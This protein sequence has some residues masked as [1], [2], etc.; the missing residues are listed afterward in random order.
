MHWK[1]VFMILAKNRFGFNF[2]E[3]LNRTLNPLNETQKK[4][5][6]MH[7]LMIIP[8]LNLCKTKSESDVSNSKTTARRLKQWHTGELD[9]FFNERK[10]LQTLLVKSKKKKV[11]TEAQ[12]FNKLTNIGNLLST[13]A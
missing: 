8:H 10:A 11:E 12:Q 6:A 7:A 3:I 5:Y 9:E 1:P 2:I 13:F 4:T